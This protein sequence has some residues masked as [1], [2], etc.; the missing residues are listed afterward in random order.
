M[1]GRMVE[2]VAMEAAAAAVAAGTSAAVAV[3]L[4]VAVVLTSVVAARVW[5]VEAHTLA[6]A[7]SAAR[8]SEVGILAAH[9][10]AAFTAVAHTLPEADVIS[11][12]AE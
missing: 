2:A 4:E 12:A 5:E 11:A 3:T 6:V 1:P 9:V 8:G 7:I 10:L